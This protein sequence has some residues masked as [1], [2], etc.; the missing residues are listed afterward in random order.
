MPGTRSTQA[1]SHDITPAEALRM[2][3]EG[4]SRFVNN[5]KLNRNLLQQMN[6]TKDGQWPFAVILSCMDSRTSVELIFDQGLGD[7]FS[8][9]IA[10]NIISDYILG[11]LEYATSAAG[12]ILIVVLGHTNCG[13]VKGACDTVGKVSSDGNLDRLLGKIHP[14]VETETTFKVNRDSSNIPF[15][16]EVARLNVENSVM[17]ILSKSEIIRKLVSEGKVDI[18]PAM[19]NVGTGEVDFSKVYSA[20]HDIATV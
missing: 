3:K 6:E 14:A 2:L 7:V 10:G 4:N 19:Y 1:I 16:N 5:L 17:E 18:V 12:A 9:R 13:A 15:V 11:S 8:I 20:Q